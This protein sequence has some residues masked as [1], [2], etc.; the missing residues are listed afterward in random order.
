MSSLPGSPRVGALAWFAAVVM[1]VAGTPAAAQDTPRP[2]WG[3]NFWTHDYFTGDA[4]FVDA[5]KTLYYNTQDGSE[6]KPRTAQGIPIGGT[7]FTM[8]K[9]YQPG[10]YTLSYAGVGDL[11]ITGMNA[12]VTNR[13]THNGRTYA[14]VHIPEIDGFLNFEFDSVQNNNPLRDLRLISPGYDRDTTQVVRDEFKQRVEPFSTVRFMDW[15]RTNSSVAEQ[16]SA[17]RPADYA[18]QTVGFRDPLP[19]G[20]MAYEHMIDVANELGKDVWFNVPHR[21]DEDYMRNMA[22]LIDGRLDA[23][24]KVIM[25]FSN[26]LWNFRQG[27]ELGQAMIHPD[28]SWQNNHGQ[29]LYYGAVAPKI[30]Q[31]SDVFRQEFGDATADRLEIVL[32]G[33]SENRWHVEKALEWFEDQGLNPRDYIDALSSAP[34]FS[35]AKIR[36]DYTS[37]D[38]LMNDMVNEGYKFPERAITRHMDLADEYGMKLYAYEGGQHVWFNNVGDH[39][40]V[41]AAQRDPRMGEAY[42]KYMQLWEEHN[43]G[44]LFMHYTLTG[45]E[46][47]LLKDMNQESSPKWDAVIAHL[48]PP[49]T[50]DPT[51]PTDPTDPLGQQVLLSD[52]FA[53]AVDSDGSAGRTGSAPDVDKG[54]RVVGGIASTTRPSEGTN[55]SVAAT[56]GG[57]LSRTLDT[58][59]Y[60]DLTIEVV[61]FQDPSVAYETLEDLDGLSPDWSDHIRVRVNSHD[62]TGWQTVLLDDGAWT[63]EHNTQASGDWQ[64]QSG[65]PTPTSTGSLLLPSSTWDNEM[66]DFEIVFFSSQA[67]EMWYLDRVTLRGTPVPEPGVAGVLTGAGLL[68]ITRRRRRV[69]TP[70]TGPARA[71]KL[72]HAAGLA[73]V[74]CLASVATATHAADYYVAPIAGGSGDG[75]LANP[76]NSVQTA[77]D[78]LN[79]GD[80]LHLRGGL[81]EPTQRLRMARSGTAAQRITIRNYA[82]ETPVLDGSKMNAGS[83]LQLFDADHV[84]V[85]GLRLQ[86]SHD[87][88]IH[89]YLSD[90]LE[91]VGNHTYNTWG[92]GIGV[93]GD[94]GRQIWSNQVK[95]LSNKVE[96]PNHNDAPGFDPGA[97]WPP[98]EGITIA[99]VADFEVGYNEVWDG[100]KEG[101]DMKGPNRRGLIHRNYVRDL[102]RV[103]YYVDGW[104]DLM[105]DITLRENIAQRTRFGFQV[106][107]EDGREVRNIKIERNLAFDVTG[108]AAV[109]LH[110]YERES[111]VHGID[112]VNNT[113][114]GGDYGVL[115]YLPGDFPD[116]ALRDLLIRNNI[117]NASYKP[118]RMDASIDITVDHNLEQV[119][120]GFEDPGAGDYRLVAGSPA[121]DAGHPDAAYNDPDGSR[122]DIGA[123]FLGQPDTVI[124]QWLL[125]DPQHEP[126]LGV[127]MSDGFNL[128]PGQPGP[129]GRFAADGQPDAWTTQGTF[130]TRQVTVGGETHTVATTQ[131]GSIATT[132][133]TRGYQAVEIELVVAQNPDASYETLEDL[134]SL[135]P[136]W[137][138]FLMIELNRGDGWQ[139]LL[140]DDAAWT[141]E[142]TAG[143]TA[144]WSAEPGTGT[145]TSTGWLALPEWALDQS[146]LQLRI[147]MRSNNADELWHLD[148]F[149]VRGTPVPEP[150]VAGILAAAAA[151][152]LLARPTPW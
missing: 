74:L 15:N 18:I 129:V 137:S 88:G 21:V 92:P 121:I 25:E 42:R 29:T 110:A 111:R 147:V 134:A 31:M 128:H 68:L 100:Q 133:D 34:Y 101:I 14:D 142:H 41:E 33:Q 112:V 144:A 131:S 37:L 136:T 44:G 70:R 53:L 32:A 113:L 148:A 145:P 149:T 61:L 39:D 43:P 84:T 105:E 127:I 7:A 67:E 11:S 28:W 94:A 72:S 12:S 97:R 135:E 91:I 117:L 19:M 90:H 119:S 58:R 54:W 93:W 51:D 95:V 13:R 60:E 125:G 89:A 20:G 3:F 107:S 118:I 22:R 16:W 96:K 140:L 46:W 143:S 78:R 36:N 9:G 126:T 66:V 26:E 69:P 115:A 80:T 79:P 35:T 57:T 114:I 65:N 10:T 108:D 63:G 85:Q 152:A 98:H 151:P 104:T 2:N 48:T 116:Q 62:G 109:M 38:A 77:L 81:Y 124:E 86:N 82:D 130:D 23:K 106:T 102:P 146:G 49:T 99:R 83:I 141:G 50:D 5:S 52:E 87:H 103:A 75:S 47:G 55:H 150:M 40:L 1:A 56:H 8:L 120:T 6:G 123:F 24:H 71:A 27:P 139:T 122:N 45:G 76:W 138:D 30:K 73:A 64:G 4:V 17:R 132:I 59:G